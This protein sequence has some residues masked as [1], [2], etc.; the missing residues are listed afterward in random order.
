[1]CKYELLK[2]R[3]ISTV[4][5][6]SVIVFTGW[7]GNIQVFLSILPGYIAMNPLTAI[8]LFLLALAIKATGLTNKSK[9]VNAVKGI[10]I[11]LLSVMAVKLSDVYLSTQYNLDKQF[12]SS[13][14]FGNQMTVPTVFNFVILS[15]SL[16]LSCQKHI[17]VY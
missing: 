16:L 4:I 6:V 11:L 12:F 9:H 3:L 14:L 15:F 2:N 5:I 8:N 10:V 1:M 17:K 7:V 13:K